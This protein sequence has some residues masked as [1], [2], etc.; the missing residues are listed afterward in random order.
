MPGVLVMEALAQ[1]GAVA[2]LSQPEWKGRTAY[3]A[4]IDRAK[5]RKKI[6]PG[7]VLMLETE[8]IRVKGPIG[9][10]KA[11]ACVDGRVAAEAQLTFAIG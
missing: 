5:F 4:G 9:L 1:V 2:I 7:D 8:I 10:G 3:F 6:I 11:R